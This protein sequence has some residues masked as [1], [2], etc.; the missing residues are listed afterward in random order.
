LL[1][2]FKKNLNHPELY[3][4]NL[5]ANVLVSFGEKMDF[6]EIIL[7][8]VNSENGLNR[9]EALQLYMKLDRDKEIDKRINDRYEIEKVN[10]LGNERNVY[11]KLYDI[12]IILERDTRKSNEKGKKTP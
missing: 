4:Q 9:S 7:K 12:P 1:D 2:D 11:C 10:G 6:K 8:G 5:T 3:I